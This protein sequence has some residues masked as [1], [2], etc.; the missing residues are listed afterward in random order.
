ML[1][2]TLK[3]LEGVDDAIKPFYKEAGD[4]F[5]LQ[6][7]GMVAQSDM[8]TLKQGLVDAKEAFT[9]LKT[10]NANVTEKLVRKEKALATALE[11]GKGGNEEAHAAI[12]AQ[13]KADHA[14]EI[15]GANGTIKTLRMDGVSSS[16]KSALGEA[17]F[18]PEVIGDI[19]AGA[20]GRIS[21]DAEGKQRIL[22]AQGNP[23]AGS[24]GDGYAT[25]G[26]LAK[27]LAAAKPNFLVDA[28]KGGGGKPPASQSG[29]TSQKTVPREQFNQMGQ[30]ERSA[31][32]KEG[33]RPVD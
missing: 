26:D 31:F 18:H 33:G 15:E 20:S 3:T 5:T 12:I 16:F 29:N 23:L 28:G 9:E 14:T 19:A 13:I 10:K 30:S 24:G 11:G 17:G 25:L 7:S 32:I 4:G 2:S 8:D 6:V 22:N 1:K 21:L 27:E